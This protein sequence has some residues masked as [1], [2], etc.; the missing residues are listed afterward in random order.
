MNEEKAIKT[1][2]MLRCQTREGIEDDAAIEMAI[3]ALEKRKPRRPYTNVIHYPYQPD[4]TAVQCPA[5]R[6]RL[7]TRRTMA[8]GDNYCPECG[9]A[10]DWEGIDG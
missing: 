8:K 2:F 10:I 1:L 7:R 3:K 6:R 4:V 5:C 9:Q